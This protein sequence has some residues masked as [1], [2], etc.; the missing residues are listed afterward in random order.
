MSL[1][2]GSNEGLGLRL[3]IKSIEVLESD[4]DWV[5]SVSTPSFE[6]AVPFR[7]GVASS[8]DDIVS[9]A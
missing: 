4:K 2:N 1:G 9:F 8:V 7:G 3:A 6:L 5:A